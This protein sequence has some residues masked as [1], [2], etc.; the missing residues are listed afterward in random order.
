MA[1]ILL[2]TMKTRLSGRIRR[3]VETLLGAGHH[4]SLVGLSVEQFSQGFDHPDL[5]ILL[6]RPRPISQRFRSKRRDSQSREGGSPG[7]SLAATLGR[8][9]RSLLRSINRISAYLSHWRYCRR[10]IV[11]RRPDLVYSCDLDGLVGAAWGADALNVPHLHDCHELFL[12]RPGYSVWDHVILRPIEARY[13]RTADAVTASSASIGRELQNRYGV[14]PT[15]FR[16]CVPGPVSTPI[17]DLRSEL[18][19]SDEQGI[20]LY[21]GR[22]SEGRGLETVIQSVRHWSCD[23]ILLL[24]GYGPMKDLL[25]QEARL[26]SLDSSIFFL[27]AVEPD[28]L[29]ATTGAASIG[30]VPYEPTCLNHELS[31]PNKVF[32]YLS[33]GVPI[34]AANNAEV[35]RIID[36]YKCGRLY[37]AGDARALA[38]AVDN[39]LEGTNLAAAKKAAARFAHENSWDQEKANLLDVVDSLLL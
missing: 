37:P 11:A 10:L 22:M 29:P 23:C 7:W 31:L 14:A 26:H 21:Q 13:M 12:E 17:R 36:E 15:I 2:A 18:R 9:F 5:D 20:V 38:A 27:D 30:L 33:V 1:D 4:V 39:L 8:G 6:Y 24:V 35:S 28:L 34:V 3:E 25:Q 19:L 32:E 16:N